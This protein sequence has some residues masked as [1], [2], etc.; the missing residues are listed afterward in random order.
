MFRLV[1]GLLTATALSGCSLV[2]LD[3]DDKFACKAPDGVSCKSV[4]GVYANAI[5]N[6]LPGQRRDGLL[7]NVIDDKVTTDATSNQTSTVKPT[8]ARTLHHEAPTEGSPLR[9]EVK[10]L[11]IWIAPFEDKEGILH[12]Q[13]FVYAITDTGQW[14]IERSKES[15]RNQYRVPF[16]V[17]GK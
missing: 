8:M 15:I 3:A 5:E 14:M 17:V 10:Q 7:G 9:S 2:G 13:K 12:D 16:P 11:R 4:S 1:F 6:N